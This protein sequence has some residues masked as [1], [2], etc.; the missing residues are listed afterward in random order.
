MNLTNKK[1]PKFSTQ[2]TLDLNSINTI[3][4]PEFLK[5]TERDELF[6]SVCT[7]QE[8]FNDISTS[9][10]TKRRSL[11]FP[12]KSGQTQNPETTPIHK[13]CEYLSNHIIKSLPE[14]FKTLD[15]APFHVSHIPLTIIN[16]LNQHGGTPHTDESGGRFSISLLY[17]FHK[18]PKAFQGGALEFYD[19]DTTFPNGHNEKPF[20]KI[21]H[22]DNLLLAFPSKTYHGVT[23]TLLDSTK[24][25]DGRFVVVGFLEPQ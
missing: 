24:F 18:K 14:I 3:R 17:Y 20:A 22:E 19:T 8:M 1:V 15:I 6:N 11:Y 21:E 4:F 12:L 10:S 9:K 13:A 25:K 7:N 5:T 16:G 23:D 2:P